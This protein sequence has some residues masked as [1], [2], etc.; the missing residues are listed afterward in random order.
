MK[1]LKSLPQHILSFITKDALTLISLTLA[2]VTSLL[3]RPNLEHVD[4][5]VIASLFSLMLI[6]KGLEESGLLETISTSLLRR[7]SSTRTLLM[8]ITM[9]SFFLSMFLTNDVAILTFLPLLYSLAKKSDINIVVGAV[10]ITVAANLGSAATPLGNPQNLFLFS[11][12]NLK[13]PQF[14]SIIFPFVSLSFVAI[15]LCVFL[16]KSTPI[17]IDLPTQALKNKSHSLLFLSLGVLV[18]SSVLNIIPYTLTTTIVV[19]AAIFT[20]KNLFK[21]VDYH[22]LLTFIF[23]FIAINNIASFENF[24]KI[25]NALVDTQAHTYLASIIISQFI[26]NVPAAILLAPFTHDV[27]ALLIG[28]NVG[29][30]GTLIASMANLLALKSIQQ[31]QPHL[32]KD[33]IKSFTFYNLALLALLGII[34]A[35]SFM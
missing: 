17:T 24:Q 5:K 32:T 20:N 14:F 12:F 34:L 27:N 1:T 25:I 31:N 21:F 15:V 33:F 8:I 10:L 29:G 4:W 19:F 3:H 22:L 2:I 16:Q 13:L 9:L 26:S 28:V 11:H 6:V 7:S 30:L 18:I 23:L 35:F